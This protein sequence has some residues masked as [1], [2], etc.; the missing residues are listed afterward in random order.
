[1]MEYWKF[2]ILEEKKISGSDPL[3]MQYSI[4]PAFHHSGTLSFRYSTLPIPRFL[5]IASAR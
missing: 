3:Q 1:M 2:G 4:I 5:V